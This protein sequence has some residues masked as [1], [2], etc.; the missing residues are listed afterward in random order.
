MPTNRE[1][2]G[3]CLI[4]LPSFLGR[5]MVPT[6]CPRGVWEPVMACALPPSRDG[7]RAQPRTRQGLEVRKEVLNNAGQSRGGLG[8]SLPW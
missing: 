4:T 2:A 1:G 6:H 8:R 3:H 7:L 5:N